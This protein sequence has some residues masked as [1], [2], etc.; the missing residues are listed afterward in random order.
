[1][2]WTEAWPEQVL[3]GAVCTTVAGRHAPKHA[4]DRTRAADKR[5][6]QGPTTALTLSLYGC[7]Y[8][9]ARGQAGARLVFLGI[10]GWSRKNSTHR[11]ESYMMRVIE[12]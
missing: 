10:N 8:A 2:I 6:R 11:K 3:I 7:W 1:M 5:N 4:F 9:R 12:P